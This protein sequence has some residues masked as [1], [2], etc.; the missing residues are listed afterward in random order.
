MTNP[1]DYTVKYIKACPESVHVQIT[2][3]GAQVRSFQ[4]H[5]VSATARD[6]AL[7]ESVRSMMNR[8]QTEAEK[9]VEEDR[10]ARMMEH[11]LN[12][13]GKG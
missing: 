11:I 3:S 4:V 6:A 12:T 9:W 10:D 7:M 1:K 8:A 2:R 5:R 13:P